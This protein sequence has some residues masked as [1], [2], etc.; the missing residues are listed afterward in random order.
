MFYV[1]VVPR[2]KYHTIPMRTGTA[3]ELV[4]KL[5]ISETGIMLYYSISEKV[6]LIILTCAKGKE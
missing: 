2:A 6:L 5:S 3:S 4:Y 1:W